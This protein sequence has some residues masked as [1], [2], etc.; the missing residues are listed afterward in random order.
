[1]IDG[2]LNANKFEFLEPAENMVVVYENLTCEVAVDIPKSDDN[3]KGH[4]EMK[5]IMHDASGVIGHPDR[6]R[7]DEK[8]DQLRQEN[9]G[10]KGR[11][12]SYIDTEG[13]ER[14]IKKEAN[15]RSMTALM[16]PSGSGKT[17]LMDMVATVKT[18]PFMGQIKVNG[19][20]V[21]DHTHQAHIVNEQAPEI[22]ALRRVVGYVEQADVANDR[23][24]VKE[25]LL[26][27]AKLKPPRVAQS[28]VD[29]LTAHGLMTDFEWLKSKAKGDTVI[30][31][32][33]ITDGDVMRFLQGDHSSSEQSEHHHVDPA[34]ESTELVPQAAELSRP[35]PREGPLFFGTAHR[36]HLSEKAAREVLSVKMVIAVLRSLGLIK[37]MDSLV[38]N[39]DVRGI[40][41][42]QKKRLCIARTLVSNPYLIFLDEPTSGLSAADA[43]ML[44]REVK[45]LVDELRIVAVSVIH[46]PRNRLFKMFD[47][48]ILLCDGKTIY[49]G[50]P[51][52]GAAK[53]F[54]AIE[55]PKHALPNRCNPADHYIDHITS[56]EWP[57]A[58]MQ[59]MFDFYINPTSTTN[60]A[61][62]AYLQNQG[63]TDAHKT[64]LLGPFKDWIRNG[65]VYEPPKDQPMLGSH[66]HVLATVLATQN[67]QVEN[68]EFA[69][70]V[71]AL[72]AMRH[73]Q[74][75]E[76]D[77]FK[78]LLGREQINFPR[79][80]IR[81]QTRTFTSIF[82]GFLIG[83]IYYNISAQ[84]LPSWVL[85]ITYIPLTQGASFGP[86]LFRDRTFFHVER[87]AGLYT[88]ATFYCSMVVYG[89]VFS[90]V[91]A[92]LMMAIAY[93]F[94]G[95]PFWPY[96]P[97][98][99]LVVVTGQ[100]AYD[101]GLYLIVYSCATIDQMM[102]IF[103]F[104]LGLTMFCNGFTMNFVTSKSWISWLLYISPIFYTFEGTLS[105]F[106]HFGDYDGHEEI[107][108]I[109]QCTDKPGCLGTSG[110][111]VVFRN[112]AI[113]ST[114]TLMFHGLAYYALL[115]KHA[116]QR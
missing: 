110:D 106:D 94:S 105:A 92:L 114:I 10:N 86:C 8:Y 43:I 13:A 16:G 12:N 49:S 6:R 1:M 48:L 51:K 58:D 54:A 11:E 52:S 3:P 98:M 32:S 89:M 46:Q 87:G 76:S 80:L 17:T 24:T 100:C 116:P 41:G 101:A 68:P 38:G 36:Y 91:C 70:S 104:T 83:F 22:L 50:P 19:H 77:K 73:D 27:F 64:D 40:S 111:N 69:V 15:T 82:M 66:A 21:V 63:H 90:V 29:R 109:L 88:T 4:K 44:M 95:L 75:S 113:M 5:T 42:G 30:M 71:E 74:M 107:H 14:K 85:M 9:M 31:N 57:E 55:H 62:E 79:D 20:P 81:F 47:N 115:T 39:E 33:Q 53:Y 99:Y 103:N 37:V 67:L 112:V 102:L 23:S 61:T 2:S 7:I 45:S 108:E 35:D 93:A 65:N 59:A 28:E 34:E 84:N 56:T 25:T 18:L 96:F 97:L 60:K 78:V 26:F 72:E